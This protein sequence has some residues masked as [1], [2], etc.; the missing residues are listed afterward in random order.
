MLA[1][2]NRDST[3]R[4]DADQIEREAKRLVDTYSDLILR[5]CYSALGS[6][7][8]AQDIC[9]DTLV[10]ILQRTQPFDSLEHERAWVIRVALNACRDIGRTH[11]NHPVVDLDSLPDFCAPATHTE[12]EFAQRDRVILSAVM[13]LPQAQRIAIFLHYYVGMS[14]REIADAV[15]ATPAAT[16]QHLSRGRASLRLS[17]KGDHNDYEFE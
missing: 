2:R 12:Q 1:R 17:L 13:A 5:L 6:T 3:L 11:A 7:D 8:D 4:C 14:I 10:K 9:Q 16:A 15:H